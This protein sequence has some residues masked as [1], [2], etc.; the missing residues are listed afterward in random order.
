PFPVLVYFH[1]GGWVVGNLDT[2]DGICRRLTNSAGCVVVSV[3]YRLAPEHKFPAA[4]EDCYAA[5]EWI[6]RHAAQFN[7]DSARVAIGG[8]SCGGTLTAVVTQMARDQGSLQLIFQV[9]VCPLTDFTANTP[10]M[11][12]YGEGYMETME[13]V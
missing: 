10:S 5:T 6:A 3:D 4:P 11:A 1:G 8:T 9:M 2:E 12:E 13:D 7:G